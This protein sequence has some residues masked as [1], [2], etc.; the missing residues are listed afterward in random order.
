[1]LELF[2]TVFRS[3]LSH[4]SNYF[5]YPLECGCFSFLSGGQLIGRGKNFPLPF[6]F[7]NDF[8]LVMNFLKRTSLN[9]CRNCFHSLKKLIELFLK[10]NIQ[11]SFWYYNMKELLLH[12]YL[13]NSIG[14]TSSALK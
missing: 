6:F 5:T 12:R 2:Y 10:L 9:F 3:L 14:Q 1:M 4:H 7:Q 11:P 13:S 8:T